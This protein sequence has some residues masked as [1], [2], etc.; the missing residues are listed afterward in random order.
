MSFECSPQ[1]V[2]LLDPLADKMHS[3]LGRLFAGER[4]DVWGLVLLRNIASGYP[5]IF[6]AEMPAIAVFMQVR[7]EIIQRQVP[8]DVTV[9]L[10][11]HISTGVSYDRAPDL[12]AR[13]HI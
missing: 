11:V 1:L 4:G 7:L 8:S 13:L 9:E 3:V 6:Q 12:L 5:V 2:S 10:A